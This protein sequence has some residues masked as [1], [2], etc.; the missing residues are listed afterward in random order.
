MKYKLKSCPFCG[1]DDIYLAETYWYCYYC[2]SCGVRGPISTNK[3]RAK[4]H[5]NAMPRGEKN[6]N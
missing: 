5:W 1:E 2:P 3:S 4:K 6:E